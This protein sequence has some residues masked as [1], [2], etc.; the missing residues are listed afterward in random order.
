MSRTH[1]AGYS[2]AQIA[3]HWAIAALIAFQL[4]FAE[5]MEEM[6]EAAEAGHPLTGTASLM[7]DLHIVA[8]VT[9]LILAAIR[10]F[11]KLTRG[12]PEPNGFSWAAVRLAEGVHWLFYALMVAAPVSGLVAYYVSEAAA[13]PHKLMKPVFIVLILL[14]VVGALWHQM[15]ARD[16]TMRRMIAPSP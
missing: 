10:L 2:A 13:G 6:V 15:V 5:A 12:T 1:P 4:I 14:H 3:L 7:G 9:V 16:A 8:G 11:L